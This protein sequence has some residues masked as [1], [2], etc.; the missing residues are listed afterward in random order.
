MGW[1]TI[2]GGSVGDG[3]GVG[4]MPGVDISIV[5]EATPGVRDSVIKALVSFAE[6]EDT[7]ELVAMVVDI[8][9][10]DEDSMADGDGVGIT[11]MED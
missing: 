1:K 4:S 8:S 11:D 3:V 9:G 2:G 6:E 10:V 5:V 7:T